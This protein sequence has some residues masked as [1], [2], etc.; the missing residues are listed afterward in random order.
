MK[1]LVEG[2]FLDN[3][4][5]TKHWVMVSSLGVVWG[6]TFLFI[7]LA[8]QGIT[9]LWLTSARIV[10][11]AVV[12]SVVWLAYGGKLFTTNEKTWGRLGL[13]GIISTAL[14]FQLIS[15]GQLMS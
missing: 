5:H 11:A 6:S 8:L 10:F 3:S 9:P 14:P 13:I 2:K 7:E 1:A 4:I 12:T 15:W